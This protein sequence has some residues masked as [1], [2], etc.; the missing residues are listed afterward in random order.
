[1]ISEKMHFIDFRIC[2]GSI[3]VNFSGS[4]DFVPDEPVHEW[5]TRRVISPNKNAAID[6][7][8]AELKSFKDKD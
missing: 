5:I 1:M 7:I 2:E 4:R 6:E 3:Q 8:I